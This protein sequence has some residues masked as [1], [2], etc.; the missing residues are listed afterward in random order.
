MSSTDA[1]AERQQWMAV[2]ALAEVSELSA[3]WEA[4]EEKPQVERIRG[5]E[6]GIVMVRGR[7]GSGGDR[8]NLGEATV[9]R[10]SV[11]LSGGPLNEDAFGHS[12]VLGSNPDHAWYSAVFDGMLATTQLREK[13]QQAVIRP[14]QHAHERREAAALAD[15][16]STKVDFLTFAREN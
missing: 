10:A 7:I 13:V 12:Y 9:V 3:A 15:A 4:W 14:L 11:R 2:L 5:P 1:I 16:Q 8:F 6:S